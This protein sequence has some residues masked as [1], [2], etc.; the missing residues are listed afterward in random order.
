MQPPAQSASPAPTIRPNEFQYAK[1]NETAVKPKKPVS[2]KLKRS[3]K[4]EYSWDIGGTDTKEII[5]T[6]RELQEEFTK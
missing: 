2:V 4:G 1:D 3:A 6:N 5:R